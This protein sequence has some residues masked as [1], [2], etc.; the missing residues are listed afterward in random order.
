[1]AKGSLGATTEAA[2]LVLEHE[3]RR[4]R[5]AVAE[6]VNMPGPPGE[7]RASEDRDVAVLTGVSAVYGGGARVTRKGIRSGAATAR[8]G[9]RKCGLITCERAIE[10]S[11]VI[12][13][14]HVLK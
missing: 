4:V 12:P 3:D 13:T 14:T 10:R 2:D 7:I 9:Q 1:M 6:A 5:L 8:A 11:H